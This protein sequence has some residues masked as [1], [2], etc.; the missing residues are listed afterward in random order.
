MSEYKNNPWMI[1]SL[2][3]VTALV[4][5][6]VT[7]YLMDEVLLE[8]D[9]SMLEEME[10]RDDES[11]ENMDDDIKSQETSK[12]E[13]VDGDEF[14]EEYDLPAAYDTGSRQ[15]YLK[16]TDGVT[17]LSFEY[18]E[19][20]GW[21]TQNLIDDGNTFQLDIEGAV[22]LVSSNGGPVPARGGF[23]GDEASKIVGLEYMF[24]TVCPA[25]GVTCED[26]T[27]DN[28]V[29]Y[30]KISRSVP[31]MGEDELLPVTQYMIF[32]EGS[33]FRGVMLSSEGLENTLGADALVI[34]D[35]MVKSLSN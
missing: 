2:M 13:V 24:N 12:D 16:Y 30:F 3:L 20:I 21:V 6:G 9:D 22:F 27:S 11:E 14:E 5:F 29:R 1:F 10:G 32:N 26:L 17:G 7:Y 8:G 23:W 28:G 18:P 31:V 15:G 35:E 33:D 4:T 19:A 34:L 25:E